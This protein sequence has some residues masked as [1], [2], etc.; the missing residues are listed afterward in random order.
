MRQESVAP[1]GSSDWIVAGRKDASS[2]DQEYAALSGM[3]AA[4]VSEPM[5]APAQPRAG[6]EHLEQNIAGRATGPETH[7]V[8][9]DAA[10]TVQEVGIL[11]VH[12]MGEHQRGDFLRQIGEPLYLWMAA[13][14][15]QDDPNA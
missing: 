5:T 2:L 1:A 7:A 4:G 13:W 9:A 14:L 12:G 15:G 10:T 6:A 11:F 3:A 8:D